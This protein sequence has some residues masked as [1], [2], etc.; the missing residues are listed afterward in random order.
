MSK[1]D[2]EFENFKKQINERISQYGQE[3]VKELE[4]SGLGELTEAQAIH[5]LEPSHGPENFMCDGEI[6]HATALANWR[7]RCSDLGLTPLVIHK[8]EKYIFG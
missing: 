7:R 1:K 6:S 2:E 4:G 8:A 5:I 3:C